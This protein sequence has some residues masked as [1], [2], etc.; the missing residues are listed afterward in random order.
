MAI[1][2]YADVSE[3]RQVAPA[4]QHRTVSPAQCFEAKRALML[5]LALGF[6]QSSE[7]IGKATGWSVGVV[8]HTLRKQGV[9]T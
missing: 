7:Q 9:A 3:A 2:L 5:N 1:V 4:T 8:R 6:N